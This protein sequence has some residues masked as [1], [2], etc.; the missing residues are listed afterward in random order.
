MARKK[1]QIS[2]QTK[3]QMIQLYEYEKEAA[4]QAMQRKMMIDELGALKEYAKKQMAEQDWIKI[5]PK[6]SPL[7]INTLA[8][9]EESYSSVSPE[10]KAAQ[11][12][13]ILQWMYENK[14]DKKALMEEVMKGFGMDAEKVLK[15]VKVELVIPVDEIKEA[16]NG[17]K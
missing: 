7:D 10:D 14:V 9:A 8:T 13:K 17:N 4:K 16:I 15:K 12:T 3:E 1:S 2:S 5:V 6:E 11:A